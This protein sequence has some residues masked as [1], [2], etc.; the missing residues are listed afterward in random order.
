MFAQFRWQLVLTYVIIILLTLSLVTFYI[1]HESKKYNVE[2]K[3]ME[4]LTQ[5]NVLSGYV[6]NYDNNQGISL[7]DMLDEQ[8]NLGEETRI[9]LLDTDG[10]VLFDSDGTASKLEGKSLMD[11]LV[12]NAIDGTSASSNR[13]ESDGAVIVSAAAPVTVQG[14]VTGVVYVEA[15]C[16]DISEYMEHLR[17]SLIAI[18]IL[19][20]LL[21]GLLSFFFAGLI[22]RPITALTHKLK[23]I[24][25]SDEPPALDVHSGGEVGEL[26]NAFNIMTDRI[27]EQEAKRQEFV[28]NASHEL[29][30]PLSAIRL[31]SDSILSAPDASREMIDDFL[32]DMNNEVDRLTRIINK[33][34]DLTKMDNQRTEEEHTFELT[35]INEIVLSI[36]K[37]LYPLAEKKNIHFTC[38]VQ[39]DIYILLDKDRIWESI[40]NIADNSI[41]YT[42][43]GGEVSLSLTKD[44]TNAIITIQDNGIGIAPEEQH[45]IFDRFYRVDKARARDTGGT[46][47]GLA[48][49]LSG[50]ELHGGNIEVES[51]EGQGSLFRIILPIITT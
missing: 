20:S 45:M 13:T 10:V 5:A 22:L 51:E 35:N 16:N 34:L 12:L 48:I 2:Q 15:A 27:H 7:F 24:T 1:I 9:I 21:V 18:A 36:A 32:G 50:V 38:E 23:D 17:T 3:Q 11:P 25:E 28:S 33:L 44:E 47:L 30:T 31:I 4:I 29:K 37:S 19:V 6:S 49:A 40:Y 39:G 46:G 42:P 43:E 26:V 14:Q 41:K 8:G